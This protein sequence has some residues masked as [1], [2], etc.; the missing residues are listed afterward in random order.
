MKGDG[1][2]NTV[3]FDIE[4]NA[5]KN[6]SSLLG[7]KTV[8]CIGLSTNGEEPQIFSGSDIEEALEKL[9]LADVIVGH[10]IQDFDIRALKRIY[11][12][13]NPEGSVRDTL[14]MC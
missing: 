7:L 14:I 11:P 5:I 4:T 12:D 1:A 9:R 13:W 8:H 6:F 2:M 10:T 3:V